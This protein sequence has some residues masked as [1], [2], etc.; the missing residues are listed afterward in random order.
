V[1]FQ[2]DQRAV[3][4]AE[5]RGTDEFSA[6]IG[7][8]R[9]GDAD[10]GVVVGELDGHAPAVVGLDG[11]VGAFDFFDGAPDPHRRIGGAWATATADT[12]AISNAARVRI[13]GSPSR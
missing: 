2:R 4:F 9:L 1:H 12:A 6:G 3:A 10:D 13:M 11:Q 5:R 8:A 7:D